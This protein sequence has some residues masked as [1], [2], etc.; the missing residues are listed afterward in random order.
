MM[1]SSE[2][3]RKERQ[4]VEPRGPEEFDGG[5]QVSCAGGRTPCSY[6][7]PKTHDEIARAL[8][9]KVLHDAGL[10]RF[11]R[12]PTPGRPIERWLAA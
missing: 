12:E 10:A 1:K 2:R 4:R 11:E 8:K 3:S 5:A 9:L 7:R 6:S